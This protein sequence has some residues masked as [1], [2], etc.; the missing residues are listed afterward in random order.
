MTI[1]QIGSTDYEKSNV[2]EYS[3]LNVVVFSVLLLIVTRERCCK[4]CHN[5][6]HVH[7]ELLTFLVTILVG[8]QRFL[9][10]L[11]FQVS[12]NTSSNYMIL[13]YIFRLGQS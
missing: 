2:E 7:I 3:R 10:F 1:E 4:R 9:S 11:S 5:R 6:T 8:Q 12:W 13:M